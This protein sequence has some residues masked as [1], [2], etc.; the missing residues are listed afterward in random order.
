MTRTILLWALVLAAGAFALQWL[1]Y[2]YLARAFP[3]EIYIAIVGGGFAAGG[4]WVGWKLSSRTPAA[5]FQRNAAALA[6]LGLTGQE[7]RVLERLAAGQSNKEIART[8]GLSPNTVKTHVANLFA[9][10]GASRRTQAV[11]TARDLHL[12]P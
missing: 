8:L 1:Q 10:L 5:P 9:K 11:N 2:Q 12:I 4:V 6:S 7:L 3:R